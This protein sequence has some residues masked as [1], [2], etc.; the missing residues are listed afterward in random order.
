MAPCRRDRGR[1]RTRGRGV[2]L[3]PA[4]GGRGWRSPRASCSGS[5][6]VSPRRA[7]PWFGEH[8]VRR[9][10]QRPGPPPPCP[11]PRPRAA[12]GRTRAAHHWTQPGCGRRPPEPSRTPVPS[13]TRPYANILET[14][15]WT[16]LVRLNKVT[17]GIRTP[18]YAKAEFF[19][20]GGS[21]KD[22]IGLAMIEAAE[23]EGRIPC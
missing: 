11:R 10:P 14:I 12:S 19:N 17:Q 15:G 9:P 16:P 13:H 7:A 6:S 5:G 3:R 21:V 8:L 2:A 4:G 1:A 18:V 20:P 22:R 23:R